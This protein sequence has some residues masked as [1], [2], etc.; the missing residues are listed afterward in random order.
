MDLTENVEGEG[1]V[2]DFEAALG[3]DSLHLFGGQYLDVAD[4]VAL[5]AVNGNLLAV[6]KEG[7]DGAAVALA[8]HETVE[9]A[10]RLE[11]VCHFVSGL[12][13]VGDVLKYVEK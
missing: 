9:D 2:R 3:E 1:G 12:A 11:H 13:N 10:A 8:R 6:A 5:P 4:V 7:E